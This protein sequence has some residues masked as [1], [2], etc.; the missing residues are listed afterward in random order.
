M[1]THLAKSTGKLLQDCFITTVLCIE[2]HMLTYLCFQREATVEE[3]SGDSDVLHSDCGVQ[4]ACNRMVQ[5]I[6]SMFVLSKLK[7][8]Q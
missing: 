4:R 3:Y 5:V 6:N 1:K 8:T 2:N 7:A